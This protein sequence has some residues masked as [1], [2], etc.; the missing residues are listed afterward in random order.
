MP[1]GRKPRRQRR[2]L[3]PLVGAVLILVAS[4]AASSAGE[5]GTAQPPVISGHVLA[6]DTPIDGATVTLYGT[7]T[8]C[9]PDPCFLTSLPALEVTTDAHGAFSMDLSKAHATVTVMGLPPG[10]RFGKAEAVP[11][12][13]SLYLIASGGNAG[14]GFNAAIKLAL[15][16]GSAAPSRHVVINEL[17]TVIALFSV[18]PATRFLGPFAY[19]RF[20]L[21]RSLIQPTSAHLSELFV[22]GDNSPALVNGLADILHACVAS[23]RPDSNECVSLFQLTSPIAFNQAATDTLAA[24][25]SIVLHPERDPSALFALMPKVTPYEPVLKAPPRGWLLSLN[26]TGGGMSRPTSIIAVGNA[27]WI[28]NA[29]NHSITELSSDPGSLGASLAGPGGIHFEGLLDPRAL[30]FEPA[31]TFP[32]G[33]HR[34]TGPHRPERLRLESNAN[35]G[36]QTTPIMM[37]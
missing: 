1:Q 34:P 16:L 18:G 31:E 33:T 21:F 28:I 15:L 11:A 5:T 7:F 36:W 23:G 3:A 19:D 14:N 35:C 10:A 8:E 6:G 26:F 25:Q 22:R 17:T 13:G 9:S 12:D 4:A 32:T 27:L 30:W 20:T 2:V 24:M 37:F 29:G